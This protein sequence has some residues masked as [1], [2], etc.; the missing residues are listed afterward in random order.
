[1][2]LEGRFKFPPPMRCLSV[3]LA[4]SLVG[5][6]LPAPSRADLEVSP[7]DVSSAERFNLPGG[8][9]ESF[10]AS[11][12]MVPIRVPPGPAGHAPKL[13]LV[14]SGGSSRG[15]AGPFGFGWTLAGVSSISRDLKF[16]P[17]YDYASW[18][19]GTCVFN[20][21]PCYRDDFV[22]DGQ[23]LHCEE[24]ATCNP[25]GTY[26]TQQDDGR[27]IEF[28]P[29][30][31]RIYDREG[32]VLDFGKTFPTR[33]RNDKNQQVYEWLLWRVEDATGNWIE[34]AYQDGSEAV[35]TGN[36][37]PYIKEIT[38]G[39]AG[40]AATRK[41][42]FQ[43]DTLYPRLP[44]RSIDYSAG[45]RLET[46]RRVEK[47]TI[48]AGNPYAPVRSYDLSYIQSPQ[49]GRSLLESVTL[50]GTAGSMLSRPY[51]FSYTQYEFAFPTSMTPPPGDPNPEVYQDAFCETNNTIESVC[52][53]FID[54]D[55]DAL[56]DWVRVE[57]TPPQTFW[58][59]G[60]G[61]GFAAEVTLSNEAWFP[62]DTI[63]FG[64]SGPLRTV[65]AWV[66]MDGDGLLDLLDS[67][68]C[69]WSVRLGTGAGFGSAINWGSVL[70]YDG[71]CGGHRIVERLENHP[72][73]VAVTLTDMTGDGKPDRILG[74]ENQGGQPNQ[75]WQVAVNLGIDA[76]VG[77]GS[78]LSLPS[79]ENSDHYVDQVY[80]VS[81]FMLVDVNG[82]GLPDRLKEEAGVAKV[83]Y[84]FGAGFDSLEPFGG[85]DPMR[86][87]VTS[88]AT[89]RDLFDVNGDGFAD[90]IRFDN[91]G[92]YFAVYYGNGISTVGIDDLSTG[93]QDFV[94]QAEDT[95]SMS[96]YRFRDF[97]DWNG[98]GLL[99]R[100]E[101]LLYSADLNS[102]T[103]PDLLLTASTPQDSS[104]T[105]AYDSSARQLDEGTPPNPANPGLPFV[106]PVVVKTTTSDGRLGTP[107]LVDE[108]EY[109]SGAYDG[110]EREFR[111]FGEVI[112]RELGDMGATVANVQS[113][114]LTDRECARNLDIRSMSD[115]SGELVEMDLTYVQGSGG[116]PPPAPNQPSHQWTY[117]LVSLSEE[118]RLEG[119]A[120]PAKEYSTVRSYGL[121]DYQ[122][123][124]LWELGDDAQPG[125]ERYTWYQYAT[126]IL[127]GGLLRH[128]V[129]SVSE[130]KVTADEAGTQVVSHRKL[131]Y[132]GD[133]SA[134]TVKK[135]QL[136]SV[137]SW[138]K[139]PD[140]PTGSWVTELLID[141]TSGFGSP[142]TVTGAATDDD[143]NGFQTSIAYDPTF[144]TFP[145]AITEGADDPGLP[146]INAF[147]YDSCPAGFDAAPPGSGLPCR[148]ENP[149]DEEIRRGY[150][151]LGRL[152][153]EQSYSSALDPG[154]L[155]TWDYEPWTSGP[156]AG[157]NPVRATLDL[158]NPAPLTLQA[159]SYTDGL[160]RTVREEIPHKSSA[161]T[162]VVTMSEYDSRGRLSS[163][164]L[165]Y[166]QPPHDPNQPTFLPTPAPRL[167]TLYDALGRPSQVRDFGDTACE[168]FNRIPGEVT[169]SVY[170]DLPPPQDPCTAP[171]QTVSTRVF[172]GLGRAVEVRSYEA[173][174]G[175]GVP[176][177]VTVNYDA[178]DRPVE[179]LDPIGTD[180]TL[181]PTCDPLKH[182]TT[183]KYDTMSR[184]VEVNDPDAGLWLYEYDEAGLLKKRIDPRTI[185][186][187]VE[188]SYSYDKLRRLATQMVSPEG[189]GSD[190]ATFVWGSTLNTP[191]F[192]RLER[193]EA[194][195]GGAPSTAGTHYD[196]EYDL[197][198]RVAKRTQTTKGFVFVDNF[199]YDDLDRVSV[200]NFPSGLDALYSYD[201][202]RLVGIVAN[203][204]IQI[205]IGADYDPQGR[206]ITLELGQR[207]PGIPVTQF[208][209]Q[210]NSPGEKLSKIKA[211]RRDIYNT[212]FQVM[213]VDLE[214]DGLGRLARQ[215]HV[216]AGEAPRTFSYDGL[217]RLEQAVGPW[218]KVHG[219]SAFQTWDFSYDPL[220]NLKEIAN[221]DPNLYKRAY[222]FAEPRRLASFTESGTI[223]PLGDEI[224]D[225]AFQFDL[226]GNVAQY[227]R[228]Q[229]PT[230]RD[231]V[232]N[233]QNRLH[234]AGN[235]GAYNAQYF[236]DAFGQRT[237]IRIDEPAETISTDLIY[238][239]DDFDYD[240]EIENYN[241]FFFIGDQRIA[242]TA[243]SCA[244]GLC[245]SGSSV[246]G[247]ALR[248]LHRVPPEL[249]VG[250]GAI[251]L[252]FALVGMGTVAT[253]CRTRVLNGAGAG[254]VSICLITLP[255]NLYAKGGGL[256]LGSHGTTVFYVSDHLGST[257]HV[258]DVLG[259]L[260]ESRDYDPFGRSIDHT[261]DVQLKHRFTSQPFEFDEAG[262]ELYNYGA[263][264]YEPL[265]GRFVSPDSFVQALTSEGLNR[266]SYAQNQPTT[267]VDPTGNFINI[268]DFSGF[269][270]MQFSFESGGGTPQTLSLP[271]AQL[272]DL[273]IV[274]GPDAGT[275]SGYCPGGKDCSKPDPG[276]SPAPGPQA[277]PPAPPRIPGID[278]LNAQFSAVVLG[279][280]LADL[281]SAPSGPGREP[282][283]LAEEL[284]RLLGGLKAAEQALQQ[285]LE[286]LT[287]DE[288]RRRRKINERETRY[289]DLGAGIADGLANVL[290]SLPLPVP[291]PVIDFIR[292]IEQ[293]AERD[294]RKLQF[295]NI[296]IKRILTRRSI[297]REP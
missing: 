243:G 123:E 263:R 251:G 61:N 81:D 172:D 212:L 276:P 48:E 255:Y 131:W 138:L 76:V 244:P 160:G 2:G 151:D 25:Y 143:P 93:A 144:R 34:Y 32:R 59:K 267:L 73:N 27:K 82:D 272:Q 26:K 236:Y 266:Y 195:S 51:D 164:T 289:L 17:P 3:V 60:D 11:T 228:S 75:E 208:D 210:Y 156:P 281:G 174:N 202:L 64:S 213:D 45:F 41:I 235:N 134:G 292:A 157:L 176:Y 159:T 196:L 257:R 135:G 215:Q 171:V 99:D 297:G 69:D 152:V 1:M 65:F 120:G 163:V 161:A 92:E 52:R 108:F 124:H 7:L 54:V 105:F 197:F 190:S 262:P 133:T 80:L 127:D 260:V 248:W 221:T 258:V 53:A 40:E 103:Y 186:T 165:P 115:P 118:S 100:Q 74:E 288:L 90:V 72:I 287:D 168:T 240:V 43:L 125:D 284:D 242:S 137:D 130:V 179:V 233:A 28:L 245:S 271:P 47:I 232:W 188:I 180:G 119:T 170:F 285:E 191:G 252:A 277:P 132:D 94:R 35:Y 29:N 270:G 38:Y 218:E 57:E 223:I 106:Q 71:D 200:R 249:P 67:R 110:L 150:D 295:E 183:I 222:T 95:T 169:R 220:G 62:I 96:F 49:S 122:L 66:D 114:Y 128:L 256:R 182:E 291:M 20:G 14:Y 199:Q 154:L 4:A 166:F 22:L 141:Y 111:G 6:V 102:G 104:V 148:I 89:V 261:G 158:L 58:R 142:T 18:A 136:T 153:K 68:T 129:A 78:F 227:Q 194:R 280:P 13:G 192:H 226:A 274:P 5:L 86:S 98:D 24:D 146:R 107:D 239:G 39:A 101:D 224:S 44:D 175:T 121:D 83:A 149:Q 9:F 211:E 278:T 275:A 155:T 264:M 56:L 279:H 46:D 126:P 238:V 241:Q 181:C 294:S 230:T 189:N 178:L 88:G 247:I 139:H 162:A 55:G 237:R 203:G 23:D 231:F 16:G 269:G 147:Y 296:L 42:A 31:W 268:P 250:L 113:L 97:L 229:G 282:E 286:G 184:R 36:G 273:E 87:T 70:P 216:L 109:R 209:Y 217:K 206:P 145:I 246:L 283:D 85:T 187:Q 253:R 254:F 15:G 19:S 167:S 21:R 117:C 290:E 8:V 204:G 259:D 79:W 37:V 91:G 207:S 214:F 116:A 185:G 84:N 193:V 30:G 63:E 140:Q 50:V 205:L 225:T 198:G 77:E 10:G 219:Q 12:T 112:R 173:K 201:G 33:V 293:Q 265:W 177:T 234:K